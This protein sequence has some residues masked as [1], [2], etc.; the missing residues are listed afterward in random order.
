[1]TL[2][3]LFADNYVDARFQAQLSNDFLTHAKGRAHAHVLENEEQYAAFKAQDWQVPDWKFGY[4]FDDDDLFLEQ[5]GIGSAI[6]ACFWNIVDNKRVAWGYKQ[7]DVDCIG[8][9]LMFKVIKDLHEV[10]RVLNKNFQGR[11]ANLADY[12]DNNVVTI[13]NELVRN[14]PLSFGQDRHETKYGALVFDKRA[15][16]C[17]DMWYGRMPNKFTN[18]ENL[19][20]IPDYRVPMALE[21]LGLI[22]FSDAL[23]RRIEEEKLITKGSLIEHSFRA[24]T[25]AVCY[26]ITQKSDKSIAQIDAYGWYAGRKISKSPFVFTLNY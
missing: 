5:I 12:C 23:L 21:N 25:V 26:N 8:S 19:G 18:I 14:L 1:M 9:D 16:L 15:N 2:G 11:F 10:G 22:S 7:E 3:V 20:A 4:F 13:S 6:N 24:A 17:P